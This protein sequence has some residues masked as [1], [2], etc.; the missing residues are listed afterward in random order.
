MKYNDLIQQ[1][2]REG[3]LEIEPEPSAQDILESIK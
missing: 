3:V 2:V 1:M